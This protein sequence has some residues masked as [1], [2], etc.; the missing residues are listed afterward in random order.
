MMIL[1]FGCRN[2]T[3]ALPLLRGGDRKVLTFGCR[4]PTLTLPLLRGGDWKEGSHFW[5]LE[6][7]PNPPLAK[8]RGLEGL[9]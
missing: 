8:G 2:P 5:V 3:L 9:T 4:N 1:T 6:P 7:H